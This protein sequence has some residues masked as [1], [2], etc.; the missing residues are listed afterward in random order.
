MEEVQSL[1][2]AIETDLGAPDGWEPPVEFTDSLALCALDCVYSLRAH[3][4]SGIRVVAK[5]RALRQS[6]DHDSG[7]DLV[8]AMD[9]A[10]GPEEFANIVLENRGKLPGTDRLKTVGI[11]D[12]LT[13]LAGLDTP[14]TTTA[15][16]RESVGER[17]PK[18]AWLSV[19]GLGP[20]SWSYLLMN[21]GVESETKPDV[22]IKRYLTRVLGHD[23]DPTDV[24]ARELL[25][26]AA[27]E[28]NVTTR[29]LDRAIWLYESPSSP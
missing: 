21:A 12:G 11:Y 1:L 14:V 7:L 2:S 23:Q 5:Y 20:L 19:R 9:A 25:R 10:G 26:A 17:A 4:T 16:L 8:G 18:R 6:A 13:Q 27:A 24:H 15:H 29:Q 22:M 28:L 3:S